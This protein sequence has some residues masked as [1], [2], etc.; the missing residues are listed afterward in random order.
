MDPHYLLKDEVEFE[1]ASRG[2][3]KTGGLAS[4]LKKILKKMLEAENLLQVSYEIKP[5]ESC[6]HHFVT[7]S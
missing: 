6:H 3:T 5:P 1:L 4:A 7:G 2:Y